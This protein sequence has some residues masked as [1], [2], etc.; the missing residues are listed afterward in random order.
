MHTDMRPW[1]PLGTGNGLLGL[2]SIERLHMACLVAGLLGALVIA[3][4]FKLHG[5]A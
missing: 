3:V 4:R 2:I 1:W 5:C